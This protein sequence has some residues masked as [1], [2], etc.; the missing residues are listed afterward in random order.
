[1]HKGKHVDSAVRYRF[2]R[3]MAEATAAARDATNPTLSFHDR[4]V[5]RF[6]SVELARQAHEDVRLAIERLDRDCREECPHEL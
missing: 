5:A 2:E 4:T 6:A 1:M 3:K